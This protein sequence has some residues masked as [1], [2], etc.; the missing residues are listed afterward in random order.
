MA[1][2]A[3][4]KSNDP[5]CPVGA[6]IVK[7][8]V[9]ISTG[10]NGFARQVFDD[11][12][13]LVDPDEKLK[14]ICHAEQNA[15]HNATRLGLLLEG[16][17]IYVTKFPCLACCNAIIQAGITAIHT[18][19]DKFWDDDPSD[20]DHSRKQSILRQAKIDVDA[21]FHPAYARGSSKSRN[22]SPVQPEL[23]RPTMGA[24]LVVVP[25]HVKRPSKR[26]KKTPK[27]KTAK[28][29]TLNLFPARH[30]I[31]GGKPND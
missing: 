29:R 9:M 8:H 27:Q 10:F 14:L 24:Q 23:S 21:P 22:V 11:P 3:A 25:A 17:S 1:N 12:R 30:P 28:E 2:T 4:G 7:D 16:T 20:R 19:D 15:I 31:R 18:H 6:V 26:T 5:R 13:L